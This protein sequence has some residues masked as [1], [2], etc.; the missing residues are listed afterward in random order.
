MISRIKKLLNWIKT[1]RIKFEPQKT[2]VLVIHRNPAIR[3]EVESIPLFLDE[4]KTQPLTYTEHAKFL[5]ITFSNTGTFHHH[6]NQSLGKCHS[7]IRMLKRFA[8]TVN[9]STLYKA[10]RTAIEPIA[11]YGTEVLYENLSIKV[12]E[13]YAIIT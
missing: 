8:G 9:P 4:E 10:Y 11:L 7:R 12:L 1:R 3:R 5:G 6:I 13:Y 2:H